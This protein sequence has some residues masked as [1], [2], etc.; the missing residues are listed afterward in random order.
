LDTII[1]VPQRHTGSSRRRPRP[2]IAATALAICLLAAA[3]CGSASKASTS[4]GSAARSGGTAPAL[5]TEP[6]V[7]GLQAAARAYAQAWLT[8]TAGEIE[9][10]RAGA[11]CG[12]DGAPNSANPPTLTES[13]LSGLRSIITRM[14]GRP[15]DQVHITSIETRDVTTTRGEAEAVYDL[16]ESATGNDN[17]LEYRYADGRWR[18]DGCKLTIGGSSEQASG[19]APASASR[20][21]SGPA[22]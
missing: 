19:S 10:L 7:A 11:P 17:W 1:P 4:P 5:S 22:S 16:P 13:Q 15:L 21:S 14:V 18:V 2:A 20:S 12:P 6:G 8:G 9:H 3:G